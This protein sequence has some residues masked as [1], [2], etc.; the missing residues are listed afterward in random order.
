MAQ[1]IVR[2][3]DRFAGALRSELGGCRRL[4]TDTY[5]YEGNMPEDPIFVHSAYRI[6]AKCSLDFDAIRKAL[7]ELIPKSKSFAI[8]CQLV[9]KRGAGRASLGFG[10]REIEV[11]AGKLLEESGFIA[12]LHNPDLVAVIV[13]VGN[14]A[15]ISILGGAIRKGRDVREYLNRA[16]KKFIEAYRVFGLHSFRIRNTLDIGAAPGGFSKAM[17]ELGISVVSVDPGMLDPALARIAKIR[18]ERIRAEDFRTDRTFDLITDDMN[19]HPE[20]SARIAASFS[21]NL[22]EGGLLLMT[23][24]CPT[25]NPIRYMEV[26]MGELNGIFRNFRFKHLESNKSEVM[27]LCEKA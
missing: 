3:S 16:E 8:E 27:L 1:Y 2:A 6:D 14:T 26:A 10:S 13:A 7:A 22:E 20:Q 12:N 4:G 19:M 23:V 9:G 25:R 21:K 18:H 5:I 11:R 15:Y 17:A 24:K